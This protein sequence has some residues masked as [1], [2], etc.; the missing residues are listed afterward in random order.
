MRDLRW[1]FLAAGAKH[2]LR[3]S[4]PK[5]QEGQRLW[6]KYLRDKVEELVFRDRFDILLKVRLSGVAEQECT[7]LY[8]KSRLITKKMP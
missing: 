4:V 8:G 7:K 3:S 5:A 1:R 2:L 6:L